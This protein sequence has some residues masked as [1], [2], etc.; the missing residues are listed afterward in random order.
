MS[1]VN[2][3]STITSSEQE[4]KTTGIGEYDK[5]NEM[6]IYTEEDGTKVEFDLSENILRRENDSLKMNYNFDLENN[7]EGTLL[8][9][10]LN[11]YLDLDIITK[12]I[13][14]D[15]NRFYV[16]YEI[17]DNDRFIFELVY[18]EVK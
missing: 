7:T 9:K 17:I 11:Q 14:N 4:V 2:I 3:I 5:D 13:Q 18:E 1:K 8:I 12:K 16:E 10:E 15:E 6:L